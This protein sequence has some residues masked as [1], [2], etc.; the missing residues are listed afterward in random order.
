MSTVWDHRFRPCL[1][2]VLALSD[3]WYALWNQ[4]EVNEKLSTTFWSSG[5][6]HRTLALEAQTDFVN[7][8]PLVRHH[9]NLIL[10]FAYVTLFQV[11]A[12]H[13]EAKDL[14]TALLW[15]SGRAQTNLGTSCLL[16][17]CKASQLR[18]SR[19]SNSEI[20]WNGHRNFGCFVETM[21]NL[22]FHSLFMA[23]RLPCKTHK[24]TL[25]ETHRF[26]S[27]TPSRKEPFQ[28]EKPRE[29][30][31]GIIN[32]YCKCNRSDNEKQACCTPSALIF[33]RWRT[34]WMLRREQGLVFVGQGWTFKL[35]DWWVLMLW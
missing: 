2:W 25:A 20:I 22:I 15:C 6:L 21:P 32:E 18:C 33:F 3:S 14:L 1:C 7:N 17:R 13:M 29:L 9:M 34:W 4:L 11:I 19:K 23:T 10:S 35:H 5:D 16:H 8:L 28:A 31:I 24:C 27:F 26:W 12:N 30:W